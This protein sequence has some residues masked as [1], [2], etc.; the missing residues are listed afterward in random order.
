MATVK[1]QSNIISS[2]NPAAWW[3]ET[4]REG[5]FV[6]N[7]V[8]GANVCGGA[9]CEKVLITHADLL[10]Q[11]RINVV[12]DV[13]AKLVQARQLVE[14]GQYIE[15]GDVYTRALASKNFR[16]QHFYSFPLCVLKATTLL[17]RSPKE[18]L[19]SL[20]MNN[21]EVTVTYIDGQTR[22]NRNLFVSRAND[23]IVYEITK[24]GG[25][26]LLDYEFS[27]ETQD[28][29]NSR[30]PNSF[31]NL[32][33]GVRTKYDRY[34]MYYTARNDDG[35]DYG[36]VAKLNHYGGNLTV[37]DQGIRISGANS[38]II[39]LKVFVKS[40]Y[41]KEFTRL[42]QELSLLK[43]PYDKLLKQH[44]TIHQK[45]YSSSTLS[46][47]DTEDQIT[48]VL[49]E[50][51][52]KQDI[53]TDL[54]EKEYK[55][56]RYLLICSTN[57]HGRLF[58]P[59]GLWSGSFRPY[60]SAMLYSGA[61]QEVYNFAVQTNLLPLAESIFNFLDEH[62]GEFKDNAIRLFNCRGIFIPT[63]LATNTGRLGSIE[64][65]AIHFTG[66][67]GLTA[68]LYKQYYLL[69]G[70][71]KFFK[72]R[73]LPFLRE[74]AVFY[75][76][77]F[78]I[79]KDGSVLSTPSCLPESTFTSISASQDY[80]IAKNAYIDFVLC[81]EVLTDLIEG[82]KESKLFLAEIDSWQ[83]LLNA[84]PKRQL[85]PGGEIKDFLDCDVKST[86]IT[87]ISTLYE[88]DNA[89]TASDLANDLLQTA[90]AKFCEPNKQ[91]SYNLS[92]LALAFVKLNQKKLAQEAI[93]NV[94][95][96]CSMS[97]LAL[98]LNDWRGMGVCGNEIY[99]PM[100]LQSNIIIASAIQNMLLRTSQNSIYILPC[101]P[102]EWGSFKADNLL[103]VNSCEVSIAYN[104]SKS[105]LQ[106]DIKARKASVFNLILPDGTKKLLKSATKLIF[107]VEKD[108]IDNIE[109]SA[110]KSISLNFAFKPNK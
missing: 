79:L 30:T 78:K 87:N 68:R 71:A 18:F 74:V 25:S 58:N 29:Y 16:P 41:E 8:I 24:T 10:W 39:Y 69:T 57:E 21:A 96:G 99:A 17:E 43:D 7:G 61:I 9:S 106:V 103:S 97:N 22:T 45:L 54:I 84:L 47:E 31:S 26:K 65:N 89:E 20:N 38:I 14:S 42:K 95:R 2:Q 59:Y 56:A 105:T 46:F 76:D 63:I 108:T 101:M 81:K 66:C 34:F 110:G 86:Q 19:R 44:T 23:T 53:S 91:N 40:A 55:Y 62:L 75:Q 27:L 82:C 28:A 32:P 6:G 83:T 93:A 15:V 4:W 37:T 11:G 13:S 35:A 49:I 60:R 94:V 98:T 107:D 5:Y 67:A 50:N 92:M 104:S 52:K 102:T 64:P 72:T 70:N 36:A 1:K 88:V 51:V 77:Y 48:D 109:L 90:K 73:Y 80:P 100:Q 85:S 33:Q 3:G 12:P